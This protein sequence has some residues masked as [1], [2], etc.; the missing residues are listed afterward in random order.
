MSKNDFQKKIG[1]G[2]IALACLF[3]FNPHF[4]IIDVLPD[5][6]GAWLLCSAISS[7]SPINGYFSEARYNLRKFL[8]VCIARFAFSCIMLVNGFTTNETAGLLFSFVF[9]V[10]YLIFLIPA[11]TKIRDGMSFLTIYHPCPAIEKRN[12]FIYRFTVFFAVVHSLMSTLPE[13]AVLFKP[14]E[15]AL[16]DE[17]A[18]SIYYS[19][20][21]FRLAEMIII[22]SL[23]ILWLACVWIYFAKVRRDGKFIS[24]LCRTYE[25]K[26]YNLS[27]SVTEDTLK[28]GIF[29]LIVSA[30]LSFNFFLYD[31]NILP[32]AVSCICIYIGISRLSKYAGGISKIKLLAVAASFVSIGKFVFEIMFN[33]KFS[34]HKVFFDK[35]LSFY[36]PEATKMYVGLCAFNFADALFFLVTSVLMLSALKKI[37]NEHTGFLPNVAKKAALNERVRL[38]HKGLCRRVDVLIVLS[39]LKFASSVFYYIAQ[40]NDGWIFDSALTIDISVTAVYALFAVLVFKNISSEVSARYMISH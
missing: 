8:Y 13:F 40:I 14:D 25:E 20:G 39:V 37:I 3:F 26:G 15:F 12:D 23:G 6:I 33:D 27:E 18:K 35:E 5:F 36:N 7:L 16:P 1:F 9:S 22:V 38:L 31:I 11:L 4:L 28:S 21:K 19:L 17:A 29:A 34:Y 10:I 24:A 32:N 2:K 30:V